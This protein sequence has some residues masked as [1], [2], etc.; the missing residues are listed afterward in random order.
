MIKITTRVFTGK[1]KHD[2]CLQMQTSLKYPHQFAQF[3]YFYN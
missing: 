1:I 3:W 2:H